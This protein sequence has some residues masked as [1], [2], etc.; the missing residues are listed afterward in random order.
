[1]LAAFSLIGCVIGYFAVG[2]CIGYT[3]VYFGTLHKWKIMLNPDGSD[4]HDPELILG[5]F[6][7]FWPIAVPVYFTHL[8]LRR[9]FNAG[10]CL[11][12]KAKAKREASS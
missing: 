6:A 4:E 11:I 2:F 8:C 5:I 1:M 7:F 9:F 10:S 12:E 3:V